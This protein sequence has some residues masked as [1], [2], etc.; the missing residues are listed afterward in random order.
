[1]SLTSTQPIFQGDWDL[2]YFFRSS[3]DYQQSWKSYSE[4]I[5]QSMTEAQQLPH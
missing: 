3:A 5:Q 1:M 2:N 4:G